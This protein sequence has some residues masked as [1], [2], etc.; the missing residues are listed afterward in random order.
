MIYSD[1]GGKRA[2]LLVQQYAPLVKRIA[3]HLI[4]RLPASVQVEDLIQS[5]M[6]G[7]LEAA[8]KYDAGKGASFET[9][10]GIRIRGSMMDEIRKGDWIPRSVH[11]NARSIAKAIHEIEA[12]TGRDA[13]DHEVA[14]ALGI[15]LEQYH[16]TVRDAS[17]GRLFSLDEM[18]FDGDQ[19]PLGEDPHNRNPLAGIEHEAFLKKLT[20]AIDALPER[21]KL[22][23]SLYYDE[24]LNL[25]E[26]GQVLSVS[27]SRVSQ[28]HSQ[29]TIR[30]RSRL[31]DWTES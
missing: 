1:A 13:Q 28:I 14:E 9:Y 4:A 22:V 30:L 11:R 31:T 10:A 17:A 7:L 3:H 27:E 25:K 21:E 24:E 23:L 26:I 19:D 8:H 12:R 20:A 5:G 6:I 2:D 16:G 15:T 18:G 29:A